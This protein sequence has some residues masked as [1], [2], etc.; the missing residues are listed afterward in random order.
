MIDRIVID[1]RKSCKIIEIKR[2]LMYNMF[3]L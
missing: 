1:L 3:V 2:N